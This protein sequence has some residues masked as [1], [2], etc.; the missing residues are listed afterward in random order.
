MMTILNEITEC[1]DPVYKK[2]QS[3]LIP[4]VDRD[5]VLGLRAPAAHKIAKKYANTDTGE[6]FLRSLPHRYYDENVV[7][8]FMLGCLKCGA[9]ELKQRVVEFLPHVDNWAVCDGLCAHLKNF[10]KVPNSVYP[11]VTE[12]VKSGAPYTV[13]FGL[14]CL[15]DYYI[16]R[17]HITDILEICKS[18]KGGEYYVDMAVAWLISICLVKEY[19]STL[20][21]LESNAL[22]KWVHNKA[23]QKSSE[24]YQIDQDKKTYLKSLKI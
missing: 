3:K 7:H 11:F 2:F 1:A 19:D 20:P 10:F 6:A 16:D 9:E 12:C 14:V 23:I 13:R 5:T 22:D 8:A 15:L 18:I 21:L 17:E 4:T 24:S